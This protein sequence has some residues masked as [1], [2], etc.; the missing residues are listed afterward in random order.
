MDWG[1]RKMRHY[2][3]G[4]QFRVVT[5]HQSLKWLKSIENPAGRLARWSLYLQQFD[6]DIIYR[7]GSLNKVAD[8]LSRAP[9]EGTEEEEE[10]LQE[11]VLE[12]ELKQLDPWYQR[13]V[14]EVKKAP[15]KYPAFAIR[16]DRLYRHMH[17]TLNYNETRRMGTM[18]TT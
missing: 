16:G 15:E 2:L 7:K 11:T 10:A 5:D 8:A 14:Q 18:C 4:Y 9:Q 13:L 6:F 17:H 12:V 3:E 1:L